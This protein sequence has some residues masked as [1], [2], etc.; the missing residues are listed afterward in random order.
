MRVAG[1]SS[2]F[3]LTIDGMN[4]PLE[5]GLG[6]RLYSTEHEPWPLDQTD[7]HVGLG[8]ILGGD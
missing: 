2:T 7:L 3:W 4:S 6:P 8:W 1:W 5:R